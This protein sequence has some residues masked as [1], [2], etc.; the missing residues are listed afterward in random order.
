LNHSFKLT[1]KAVTIILLSF[2]FVACSTKKVEKVTLIIPQPPEEPK[3]FYID[4]YEGS[5]TFQETKALD[6]FIGKENAMSAG[7]LFKPY[8]VN[9]IDDKMYVADSAVGV[10]FV[11]DTTNKKVSMIGDSSEG[12]LMSPIGI[13]HDSNNNV[14]VSDSKLKKVYGYNPDGDL[15]FAIGKKNEFRRPTGLAINP[16]LNRLYVTDTKAHNIKVYSLDGKAL[17]KF[18]KRGTSAAGD[19]NFPTNIAIDPRNGNVVVS[20]TQNFRVQIF[21]KDGKFISKFGQIGDRAGMFARPKGIGVDTEGHIY[22]A[23]AAFNHIQVFDD[24]GRLLI[25]FGGHWQKTPGTFIQ[26]SGLHVDKNDRIYIVDGLRGAVQVFQ[27]VSKEWKRKNPAEYK[28]LKEYKPKKIK[29]VKKIERVPL[30]I[31]SQFPRE[32]KLEKDMLKF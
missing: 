12:K 24:K 1:V 23:D 14:Y 18:G 17:F 15:I 20:D 16:K 28:K 5:N 6:I 2:L 26:L 29:K 3:L 22:I 27:Y 8:G 30:D 4:T 21:D 31:P 13:A 9:G 10:V 32:E 11:F 25:Y 7:R 19:F